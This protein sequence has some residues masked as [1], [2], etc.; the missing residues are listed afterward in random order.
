MKI[1]ILTENPS[2][3]TGMAK[4]GKEVALQLFNYGHDIVYVCCGSKYPE[5]RS[6]PFKLIGIDQDFWGADIFDEIIY[7]ERPDVVLTIGDPW[8]YSYLAEYKRCKSRALFQWVGYIAVDGEKMGGGL[9][10]FWDNIVSQMDQVIAYTDYGKHALLKSFPYLKNRLSVIYHGVDE[11]VFCPLEKEKKL[12]LRTKYGVQDRFVYLVVARNQGRKNWPNLFKAW[13]VVQEKSLCP[14]GVLWPHT[15]FYDGAGH[16]IDDMLDAFKL[17]N[18]QSIF[19]FAEIARGNSFV[20]LMPEK[21][22]NVLYNVA[23]CLVSIG[24][25][26][27]GLPVI[28]AMASKTPCLLLNHSATS[29]LGAEKRSLFVDPY[30][31]L[32]GRYLTERPV[33]HPEALAQ[34]MKD[35]YELPSDARQEMVEKAYMFAMQYTWNRVGEQWAQFFKCFESPTKYPMVLEEVI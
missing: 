35:M 10:R 18:T 20:R 7:T 34:V 15:Y 25:E 6:F 5:H 21:D 32:T 23:D 1:L 11:K 4:V 28:E 24:G 27:F 13:K 12:H 2:N 16:N 19:F 30:Y 29:E 17:G 14:K 3:H 9:P 22:L 26:G 31:Y 8:F 33:P